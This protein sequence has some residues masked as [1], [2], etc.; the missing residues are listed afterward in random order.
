MQATLMAQT[1]YMDMCLGNPVESSGGGV[2]TAAGRPRS[3]DVNSSGGLLSFGLR[4]ML[5]PE[6]YCD[7]DAQARRVLIKRVADGSLSPGRIWHTPP[8]AGQVSVDV[9]VA[10]HDSLDAAQGTLELADELRAQYLVLEGPRDVLEADGGRRYATFLAAAHAAGFDCRWACM[11]PTAVGAPAP[12]G[13]RW[14]MV[15]RRVLPPATAPLARSRRMRHWDS[16]WSASDAAFAS[17]KPPWP[18]TPAGQACKWPVA[19]VLKQG[20]VFKNTVWMPLAKGPIST[21]DTT[22]PHEDDAHLSPAWLECV[23]GVPPGWTDP[24]RSVVFFAKREKKV[25]G[26]PKTF[27]AASDPAIRKRR[28]S[29]QPRRQN[30]LRGNQIVPYATRYCICAL[31]GN[32]AL[33]RDV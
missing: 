32:L 27:R 28:R 8:A 5:C 4:A 15:A 33:D 6:G 2:D 24:A 25:F 22:A 29:S 14:H 26:V 13:D 12:R 20:I 30:M 17:A 31:L 1:A 16:M 19:G 10:A 7:Q 23:S 18:T 11:A 21:L 3:L 9:I